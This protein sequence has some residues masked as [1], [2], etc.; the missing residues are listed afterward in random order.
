MPL[1]TAVWYPAKKTLISGPSFPS[2]LQVL[3]EFEICSF[4]L[5][6]SH[7]II[8]TKLNITMSINTTWQLLIFADKNGSI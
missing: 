7:V 3:H 6:K 8:I 4:S 2:T 1:K 5:N